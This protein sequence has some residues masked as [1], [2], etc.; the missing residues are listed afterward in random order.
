MT[1]EMAFQ[2]VVKDVFSEAR[3]TLGEAVEGNILECL[4]EKPERRILES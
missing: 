2:G 3:Q 1:Y 4:R